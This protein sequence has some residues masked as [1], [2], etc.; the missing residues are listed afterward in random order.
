MSG[1]IKFVDSLKFYLKSLAGLASTLSI[2]EKIA[3]KE[4]T[5]NF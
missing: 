3:V 2:E 1:E 5:I 4:L